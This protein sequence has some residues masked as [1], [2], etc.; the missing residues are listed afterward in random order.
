MNQAVAT[1]IAA[2]TIGGVTTTIMVAVI[3]TNWRAA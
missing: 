3:V 1:I 2:V